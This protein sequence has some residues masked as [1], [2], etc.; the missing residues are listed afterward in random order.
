MHFNSGA[1]HTWFSHDSTDSIVIF[2]ELFINQILSYFLWG[3]D[4]Q[5]QWNSIFSM[6]QFWHDLFLTTFSHA[7]KL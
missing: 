7:S 5:L 1:I 2:R 6:H 4:L 3:L